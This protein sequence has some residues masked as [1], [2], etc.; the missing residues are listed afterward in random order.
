MNDVLVSLYDQIGSYRRIIEAYEGLE[1]EIKD[2]NIEIKQLIK[3][4]AT[5][6]YQIDNQAG[7]IVTD[8]LKVVN[9]EK[10]MPHGHY[11]ESIGKPA[12][13]NQTYKKQC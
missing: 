1:R 10:E 12:L 8:A 5:L 11:R 7:D 9:G 13:F 6:Q 4:N 2:K 3:E